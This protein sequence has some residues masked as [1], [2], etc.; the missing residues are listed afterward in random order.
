MSF[1]TRTIP[2]EKLFI[3][4]MNVRVDEEFGDESDK[5]LGNNVKIVGQ[6]SDL[7][8]R[9]YKDGRF[10]VVGGRRTFLSSKDRLKEFR[11]VVKEMTDDEATEVSLSDNIFSKALNPV[12]RARAFKKLVDKNPKGAIGVARKMKIPKSTLSEWLSI[13]DLVEPLQ[14]ALLD[15]MIPYRDALM[16]ARKHLS[17]DEQGQLAETVKEKGKL[18]FKAELATMLGEKERRG[19]PIG[20]FV[21]RCV[22]PKELR[23][24]YVKLAGNEDKVAD[25]CEKVLVDHVKS[26]V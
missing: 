24:T 23:E 2:T 9:P 7:V 20:L 14:N 19:A 11:C 18:D 16:V 21:V 8:V 17:V 25:Y 10:G 1:K 4:P 5:M 13:L 6:L 26:K 22:L 3:D 12:L 15:G